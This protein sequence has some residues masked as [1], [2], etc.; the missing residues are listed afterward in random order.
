MSLT[1]AFTRAGPAPCPMALRELT[2]FK[3]TVLEGL[4]S[5]QWYRRAGGLANPGTT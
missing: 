1:E 4:L 5:L 3:D 2:G